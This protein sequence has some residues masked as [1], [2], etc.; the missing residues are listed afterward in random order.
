MLDATDLS[1]KLKDSSLLCTKAYINGEW[2]DADSGETF[3]VINPARGDVICSVP[4]MTATETARA[5]DAAYATQKAWAKRTGKDRA[6]V[7]RK[8]YDLMVENADDLGM[9]LTAEMGKPFAEAK[10]EVMYGAS[11]IDWFSEEA[12][13]IYGETI[14][15]HQEDKRIV[16]LKQ[17]IGVV[18][19]ITPWNFPNAMIARKVALLWPL[20]ARLSPNLPLK[21]P[22]QH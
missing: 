22:C 6:A 9:I 21:P 11:F 20:V 1:S 12:K 4:N 13:R 15:G 19:S 2:V 5:I 10:G 3:D 17:P 14:P 18:T 7:L 16:V 8:W